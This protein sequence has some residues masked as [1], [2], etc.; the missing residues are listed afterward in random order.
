MNHKKT[1]KEI[2][3]SIPK[4]KKLLPDIRLPHKYDMQWDLKCGEDILNNLFGCQKDK[5]LKSWLAEDGYDVSL[6]DF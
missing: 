6:L 5:L 1:F 2:V 4:P 3:A